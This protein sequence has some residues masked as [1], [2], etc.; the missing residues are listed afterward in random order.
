MSP[1][2]IKLVFLGLYNQ[3]HHHHLIMS[4]QSGLIDTRKESGHPGKYCT[5][6]F[7]FPKVDLAIVEMV[8]ISPNPMP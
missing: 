1:S 7:Y 5:R 3:H 8:K 4:G 6:M 2:D